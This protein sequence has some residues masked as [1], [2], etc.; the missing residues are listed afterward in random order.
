VLAVLVVLGLGLY[1]DFGDLGDA[2]AEFRWRWFGPA[3][4]L[5]TLN[6]LI[7]FVRWEVYLRRLEIRV[8]TGRN[9]AIFGA[10]LTMTLTPM[11]AGEVLKSGL[12]RRGF[13][14]PFARSAP[15]VLAER[16]TDGLG[17]VIV[18]A[19]ALIW[20]GAGGHWVLLA[21]G[22]AGAIAVAA[23]VRV[24]MPERLATARAVAVELLGPGLTLVMSLVAA[25]SWFFE[26]VAAY[27]C[28]RGLGLDVTLAETSVVFTVGTLAGALSF[29]P[30]GLGA[31]EA[32]MAGLLRALDV[33]RADAA[34]ATVLI[35]LA[36]LW[37]AVALGAVALAVE[38]RL[39][40][41]AAASSNASVP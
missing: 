35:R 12:L 16:I 13:G 7:R 37:F 26:C 11:K 5:T 39:A 33:T 2:L 34:A 31:A 23:A 20:T 25:V 4:A 29:L 22:A 3:V 38:A 9:L 17:L 6:Y 1:A 28:V 15:I 8:P 10:G 18:G 41:R 40:R 32:G 27:L 36:T 30:G 14:T 24:P 19:A 21:L